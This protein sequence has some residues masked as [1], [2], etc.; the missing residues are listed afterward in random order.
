[1]VAGSTCWRNWIPTSWEEPVTCRQWTT[2]PDTANGGSDDELGGAGGAVNITGGLGGELTNAS[3]ETVTG[4]NTQATIPD[5]C[6]GAGFDAISRDLGWWEVFELSS[7]ANV[8]LDFWAH[9]PNLHRKD[10]RVP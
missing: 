8:R 6:G 2:T 9:N 1:M 4:D 5:T 3:T 7:C 10:S